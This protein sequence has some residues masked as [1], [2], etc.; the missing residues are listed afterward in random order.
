VS[1]EAVQRWHVPAPDEV[2]W[3]SWDGE[4]VVRVAATGC[5]HLLSPLAGSVLTT[6]LES[7]Q[8]VTPHQ[9]AALWLGEA[10][11]QPGEAELQAIASVL[12]G[13]HGLGLAEP[14]AS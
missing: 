10:A 2:D 8:P 11:L 5:T 7:P 6:L 3:R 14:L 13:L 12:V 1:S 4:Y 9:L